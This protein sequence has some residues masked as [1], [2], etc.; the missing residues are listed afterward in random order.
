MNE[1]PLLAH[2]IDGAGEPVLL[3]NGG[4]M[5][6]SAWEEIAT[7][8]AAS[9]RVIRCDFRGQLLS[10]GNPSPS[11][12]PHVADVLRLLD[13]LGVG[14]AHVV[15][16]SFGAQVGLL[17]A[18]LHPVRVAS[19]IAATAVDVPPPEMRASGELLGAACR[20]A[21]ETGSGRRFFELMFAVVYS[22]AYLEAHRGELAAR[23]EMLGAFPAA[24]F[25]G[26]AQLLAAIDA[27]DLRPVLG[28]ITCPTLVIIAE[29]DGLMPRERS[30][31]LAAAIPGA[32]AEVVADSGHALVVEQRERFLELTR[33]FLAAQV[34]HGADVLG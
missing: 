25:S 1:A 5:S 9:Y 19:L 4:M 11:L 20:E 29:H 21:A 12:E 6:I 10:P 31:A 22:P 26:G 13:H 28:R 24:W 2:R 30:H 32:R 14:A 23:V 18:A 3:L 7:A 15:G 16:T 27:M 33:S 34:R 17:L 8:L